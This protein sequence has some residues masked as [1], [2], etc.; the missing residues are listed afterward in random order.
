LIKVFLLQHTHE[1]DDGHEDVKLIGVY[2]NRA[3]AEKAQIAVR[4]QPGFRDTPEGFT[5]S[6]CRLDPEQPS[7]EEGYVT[8][9]P[10]GTYSN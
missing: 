4:D 1:F 5:I 8:Y 7:W 2:S 3:N 10:D 6:E 9:F